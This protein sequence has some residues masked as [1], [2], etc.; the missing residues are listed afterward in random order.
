MP[1]EPLFNF[2]I[3]YPWIFFAIIVWSVAWK[4]IAL[5]KAA[6]RGEY[7][8]FIAILVLNTLGI[9]EIIY[10]FYFMRRKRPVSGERNSANSRNFD[11]RL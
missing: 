8:W 9:L 2:I 7:I 1:Q 3:R 10:I 5:W 6:R 4:G 11:I